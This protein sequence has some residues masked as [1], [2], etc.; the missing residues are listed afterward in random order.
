MS[1][2]QDCPPWQRAT[3]ASGLDSWVKGPDF[4]HNWPRSPTCAS[5][6]IAQPFIGLFCRLTGLENH[7]KKW[8]LYSVISVLVL[9]G[10][11]C[12]AKMISKSNVGQ[13]HYTWMKFAFGGYMAVVTALSS[14]YWVLLDI[15]TWREKFLCLKILMF[16]FIWTYNGTTQKTERPTEKSLVLF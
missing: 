15:R 4:T 16:D 10:R 6:R 14:I 5:L 8:C 7:P 13:E 3:K 12:E 2:L 1:L 11:S 9:H